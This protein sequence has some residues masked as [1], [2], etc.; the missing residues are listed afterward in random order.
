MRW[1]S[2]FGKMSLPGYETVLDP[3]GASHDEETG[4]FTLLQILGCLSGKSQDLGI[5]YPSC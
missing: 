1:D 5:S 2:R 3:F 4:I